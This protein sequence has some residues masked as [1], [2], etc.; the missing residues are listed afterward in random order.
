MASEQRY[1]VKNLRDVRLFAEP[2]LL[3][4]EN[5]K[6]VAIL[7]KHYIH[8]STLRL[9][10]AYDARDAEKLQQLRSQLPVEP[11]PGRKRVTA[12][13][14][15]VNAGRYWDAKWDSYR[16][17]GALP[18]VQQA[19]QPRLHCGQG[20]LTVGIAVTGNDSKGLIMR[21]VDVVGD[22]GQHYLDTGE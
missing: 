2:M 1:K 3:T 6:L 5:C 12:K 17:N 9:V 10:L 18:S 14:I 22:Q 15:T 21:L 20:G 19:Q 7:N 13:K 16:H 4:L 11:T 8:T